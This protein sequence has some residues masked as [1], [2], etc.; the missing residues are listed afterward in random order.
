MKTECVEWSGCRTKHGYGKATFNG[1]WK[2]AHRAAWEDRHGPI[3]NG[4]CVLHRCDNP[5]CINTDHLFLGTPK[6]NAVDRT[7]KGRGGGKKIAGVG[8]GAAKITEQTAVRIKMLKGVLSS[9][10]IAETLGISQPQVCNIMR[11]D[12]WSHVTA[13]TR[14]SI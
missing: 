4:L 12:A 14:Y 10:K 2:L 7:N 8:N 13:N 9:H 11:G 3:P 6:D 1:G 5:P